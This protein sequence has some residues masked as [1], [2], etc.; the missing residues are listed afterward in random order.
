MTL[1]GFSSASEGLACSGC[2]IHYFHVQCSGNYSMLSPYLSNLLPNCWETSTYELRGLYAFKFS[3]KL[4]KD[5][6]I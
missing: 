5:T 3:P 2:K 4:C 1:G 6:P